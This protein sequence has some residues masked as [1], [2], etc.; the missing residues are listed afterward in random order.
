MYVEMCVRVWLLGQSKKVCCK[1]YRLSGGIEST[2]V[3]HSSAA[4]SVLG[5]TA[6]QEREGTV[7]GHK[8]V[9]L[10]GDLQVLKELLAEVVGSVGVR[11][12]A[13]GGL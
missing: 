8:L 2:E 3:G 10:H 1:T 9:L 5:K 11:S 7:G 13:T 6:R 4:V 12:K